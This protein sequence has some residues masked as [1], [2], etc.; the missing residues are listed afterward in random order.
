MLG[1]P[2]Q[3]NYV[4]A[5]TFLDE[6]A[7]YRHAQGLRTFSI[8]WG[9]W[10]QIGLAARMNLHDHLAKQGIKLIDPALAFQALGEILQSDSIQVGAMDIDWST[11][12]SKNNRP[13]FF[14]NLAEKLGN[15]KSDSQSLHS[16]FLQELLATPTEDQSPLMQAYVTQNVA[17]VLGIPKSRKMDRIQ[18]FFDMGMDS[19]TSVEL[20]NRLSAD[21]KITFP[22]TL[23]FDHPN[24]SSLADHLLS[25]LMD[26]HPSISTDK[27]IDNDAE[28]KAIAALSE[29]D[30]EESLK[31]ALREMGFNNK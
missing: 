6:L 11:Y 20:K 2:G 28:L 18:G 31:Q 22:A 19:L 24:I 8:N 16:S 1:A 29:E 9:A 21:L 25:K 17:A 15:A 23:A 14:S 10:N 12:L 7:Y 5:N 27:T 30:A 3:A 4:V 26:G 13:S